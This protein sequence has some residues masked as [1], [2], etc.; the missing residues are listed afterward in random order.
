[1]VAWQRRLHIEEPINARSPFEMTVVAK[2]I[3]ADSY[4]DMAVAETRLEHL[5]SDWIPTTHF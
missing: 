4:I 1:M 2:D 3:P 5:I